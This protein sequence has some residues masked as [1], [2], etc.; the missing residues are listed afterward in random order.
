[1]PPKPSDLKRERFDYARRKPVQYQQLFLVPEDVVDIGRA[2][3]QEFPNLV[4]VCKRKDDYFRNVGP[5]IF[6]H[7]PPGFASATMRFRPPEPA[8]WEFWASDQADGLLM[9]WWVGAWL[10]PPDWQPQWSLEAKKPV[11]SNV[12]ELNFSLS[13]SQFWSSRTGHTSPL[14]LWIVAPGEQQKLTAAWFYGGYFPWE[15][16]QYA[17]LRRCKTIFRRHTTNR[18]VQVDTIANRI[19]YV[20]D[21]ETARDGRM[22]FHAL[23]W[24]RAHPRHFIRGD[25][26]PIDWVPPPCD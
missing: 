8:D 10:L 9:D 15:T 2:L 17:F 19:R 1:M 7:S 6:Y 14:S 18:Y 22:G 3:L 5:V 26:K 11:L 20:F 21:K 16:E 23:E 24:A 12:P 4:F 25:I 13:N